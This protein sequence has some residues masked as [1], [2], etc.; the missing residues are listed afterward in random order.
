MDSDL[1]GNDHGLDRDLGLNSDLGD[2]GFDSDFRF[3]DIGL[4]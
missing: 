3:R 4:P 1:G 2:L